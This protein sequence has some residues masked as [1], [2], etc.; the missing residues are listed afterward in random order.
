MAT[1]R[2]G[3]RTEHRSPLIRD[4]IPLASLDDLVFGAWD[5]IPDDAL[6]AARKA[7]VLEERHLGPIADFLSAITPMPAVF[8]NR[9]VTRINGTNVKTG[10]TKRDLAEQL[11]ADIRE[12][13]ARHQLDRLVVVWCASTEIYLKPGPEHATLRAFEQAMDRNDECIAPSML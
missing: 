8:E 5:P 2:L 10:K 3:K 12:F 11:R 7:G 6:T 13:K 4:F 1:I 9:Y